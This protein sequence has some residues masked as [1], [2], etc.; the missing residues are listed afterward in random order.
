MPLRNLIL[1]C[2]A[3]TFSLACYK[4][5]VRNHYARWIGESIQI[6]QN[7]YVEEVE[8]QK[9]FE[10]AM[11]GMVSG[12]DQY[13][14][15]IVKS[16]YAQFQES[17]D[18]EFG[19]IG[20][21]VEV[22]QKTKRLTVMSPVVNTPAYRAGLRAGDTIMEIDGNDTE[23]MT[24]KD[25]VGLMRGKPGTTIELKIRHAGEREIRTFEIARAII[26]IDSVLGDTR[27]E[28]NT[29][30]N[31]FLED[32]PDI[33]YIRLTTFGEMSTEE[34]QAALRQYET[35]PVK[36]LILDVRNNAG[37]LLSTAVEL[38]DMFIAEGKIVS[39]RGR[40]GVDRE[41]YYARGATVLP[42]DLPM[43]VL[44][45]G[46]SASASEILAACLQDHDRAVV[47]GERSYGKGTVQNVITM[48]GGRSALKLTTASYWRPSGQNIHRFEDATEEDEWGVR[49]NKGLEVPLTDEEFADVL[50]ARRQRDVV[51]VGDEVDVLLPPIEEWVEP[52]PDPQLQRAVEYLK[53]L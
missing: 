50:A 31:Y 43:A 10:D 12:L 17:L 49:P 34:L 36:A 24:L 46:F 48:E 4:K 23:G 1:L 15:F 20:I 40:D 45:N 8:P 21:V 7:E 16:D 53:G 42:T 25:S 2:F 13:S 30:W 35:H 28:D 32:H 39:T 29:D 11:Q 41:A 44:T 18:Q 14:N 27:R 52:K 5:A 38:C 33:G 26:P 22:S 47:V 6:I 19:G 37:G 9:L 51:L 3:L